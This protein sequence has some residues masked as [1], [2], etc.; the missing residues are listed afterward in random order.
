MTLSSSVVLAAEIGTL[1]S[2]PFFKARH[3]GILPEPRLN[4]LDTDRC[5]LA[6]HADTTGFVGAYGTHHWW[7]KLLLQLSSQLYLHN[8][9][10]GLLLGD[11]GRLLLAYQLL[12]KRADPPFQPNPED[13]RPTE[14]IL[15][16]ASVGL[17]SQVPTQ[18][19]G[20][21]RVHAVSATEAAAAA[22]SSASEPKVRFDSTPGI[23]WAIMHYMMYMYHQHKQGQRPRHADAHGAP[24]F[25]KPLV[26]IGQGPSSSLSSSQREPS[27]EPFQLP[28]LPRDQR[29]E[30]LRGQHARQNAF[31][32]SEP[33]TTA[34][35]IHLLVM[36]SPLTWGTFANVYRCLLNPVR[37][38][39]GEVR[40]N[41][42]ENSPLLKVHRPP[43]DHDADQERGTSTLPMA[44][45]SLPPAVAHETA[46]DRDRNVIV[47]E[48]LAR[49]DNEM[50]VY[51]HLA[52]LQGDEI[53]RLLG[54]VAPEYPPVSHGTKLIL[55]NAGITVA[56]LYAKRPEV[57]RTWSQVIAEGIKRTIRQ[58][59]RAR[60]AHGDISA[61]NVL[62]AWTASPEADDECEECDDNDE[63]EHQSNHNSSDDA[64]RHQY[65]RRRHL[66]L[67]EVYQR[68][69]EL[70]P[71]DTGSLCPRKRQVSAVSTTSSDDSPVVPLTPRSELSVRVKSRP[72]SSH[73]P[74]SSLSATDEGED[75]H[76]V[77]LSIAMRD[78]DLGSAGADLQ[79]QPARGDHVSPSLDQ[80]HTGTDRGTSSEDRCLKP[81]SP[82]ALPKAHA[83]GNQI[84]QTSLIESQLGL[85]LR[86]TLID[87]SD[88]VMAPTGSTG[89]ASEVLRRAQSGDMI[90]VN[91]L[92]A[93]V[94]SR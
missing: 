79:E 94:L 64:H 55:E 47:K 18:D 42:F 30:S 80:P 22:A 60:V 71:A 63:E 14:Y 23:P 21:L 7:Q 44:D 62:I 77:N 9:T 72:R 53:P 15:T 49:V 86:V 43:R 78:R 2:K 39:G 76:G 20:D 4:P 48:I 46:T 13:G 54:T 68:S 90:A 92:L 50:R 69:S 34:S 67:D 85:R 17:W 89:V 87:W 10:T 27:Q 40:L 61:S 29:Q 91:E 93:W 31:D 11:H 1:E 25:V 5:L 57:F 3:A 6:D 19:A 88:A 33:L 82:F 45:V 41:A 16:F 35:S 56:K 36:P 83:D 51:H 65:S 32:Y 8:V 73:R 66:S 38:A 28:Q 37:N 58:C 74:D 59:H 75:E 81:N 84:R 70:R 24:T 12:P 52:C 26:S